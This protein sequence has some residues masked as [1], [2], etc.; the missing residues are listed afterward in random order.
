VNNRALHNFG[1]A[2]V[3]VVIA[4]GGVAG[5]EAML[6]LRTLAQERVSI[7]LVAPEREFVYR[8]LSV[9]EP[10]NGKAPRFDLAQIAF[11]HDAMHRDDAVSEVDAD[12]HRLRTRA[13]RDI[14]YDALVVATGTRA[15]E[16]VSGALTFGADVSAASFA[17]LVDELERGSVRSVAFAVPAGV[18]WSLPLYELALNTASHLRARNASDFELTIV[19]PEDAP[20]G[21]FGR[22]AS[23]A[24][25]KRLE[26][27]GVRLMTAT[28]PV[29]VEPGGMS[30]V[31][32]GYVHAERVIALPR[33]EGLP[34]AGLPRDDA[35]FIPTDEYGQVEGLSD[36]YAAGDATTFPV[37]QGG[38]A[39]AQADVVAE[40]IAARVGAP[41]A[42]SPFRPVLRGFLLAGDAPDLYLSAQITRGPVLDSSVDAEPLSWQAAKISARYLAPYLAGSVEAA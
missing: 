22:R 35:G 31:P 15:R 14:S 19:T 20:L 8:P 41:V 27:A 30:V 28:H 26:E 5:L 32:N 42:P 11:D 37:K 39:A 21:V 34:P 13:G 25:R 17:V 3:R 7:D 36:V 1:G 9:L 18:A 38:I 10:F 23:E 6:A 4:G 16:V 24:V 12:R 33:L 2:P 29:A 40:A